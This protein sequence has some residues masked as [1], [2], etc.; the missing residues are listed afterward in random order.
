[1]AVT[2]RF[3][4]SIFMPQN[5]LTFALSVFHALNGAHTQNFILNDPAN[6]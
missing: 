6:M 1:M 5:P 2:E 4:Q 3:R